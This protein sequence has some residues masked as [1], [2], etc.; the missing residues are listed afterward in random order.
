VGEQFASDLS[1][2]MP[3]IRVR[4]MSSNKAGLCRLN[5]VDQG[6]KIARFQPAKPIYTSARSV[7]E[8][9]FGVRTSKLT[10]HLGVRSLST[11]S[12]EYVKQTRH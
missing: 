3:L 9:V 8:Y 2:L 11:Y 4:T 1:A 7:S 6:R 10:R 12:K 5:I